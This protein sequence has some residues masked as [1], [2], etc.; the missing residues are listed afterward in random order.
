M[1]VF[2]SLLV[3]MAIWRPEGLLPALRSRHA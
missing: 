2:G 3:V 1:T